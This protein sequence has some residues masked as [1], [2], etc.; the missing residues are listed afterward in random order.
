MFGQGLMLPRLDAGDRAAP[1]VPPINVYP[2]AAPSGTGEQGDIY[3]D[4]TYGVLYQHT[5]NGWA[6]V[7]SH[8][9]GSGSSASSIALT[10]ADAGFHRIARAAGTAITLPAIDGVYP[11]V[12]YEIVI[13]TT[14]TSNTTTVTAQSGD[15][16][17]TC[18][19]VMNVDTDTGNA[20]NFYAPDGSDDLIVTLNGSTTGGLVGSR[21]RFV[22]LSNGTWDVTG[23][24]YATG[25][26]ATCF[27]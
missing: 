14:I 13:A 3:F 22:A 7:G 8:Y 5:G 19:K 24:V 26:P 15:L 20:L 27:S 11:G 18:S 9:R 4:S 2:S 23:T 21:L 12:W 6:P 16:L 1:V 17:A 25:V 10:L